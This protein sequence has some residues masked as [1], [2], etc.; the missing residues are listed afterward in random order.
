MAKKFITGTL[1]KI[2]V[3]GNNT[4]FL[5]KTK[6][7][8]VFTNNGVDVDTDV[9][10][11]HN[12]LDGL[13]HHWLDGEKD[14]SVYTTTCTNTGI[15]EMM[16]SGS[17]AAG[18][19][20]IA[21]GDQ[22]VALGLNSNAN[23]KNSFA[24]GTVTKT[25]GNFSMT[26]GHYVT[27]SSAAID[28]FAFGKYVN[29]NSPES[30]GIGY[31]IISSERGPSGGLVN[32][33]VSVG[34]N[35][36]AAS[37]NGIAV[38]YNVA[39]IGKNNAV[40][41][42]RDINLPSNDGL[43]LGVMIN[44]NNN[45]H[46][47]LA[48]GKRI[49]QS[50]AVNGAFAMGS[51]I[52]QGSNAV[53]IGRQIASY[54]SA[55]A[56]SNSIVLIGDSITSNNGVSDSILVGMN[57]HISNNSKKNVIY[58]HN[59]HASS[60]KTVSIGIGMSTACNNSVIIATSSVSGQ[61]T[62]TSSDSVIIGY[63][64]L[65]KD[66]Y[67]DS[68][69]N[70]H[71][72]SLGYSAR[73]NGSY[74]T[75][76]GPFSH[77]K[78][79]R[80]VLIGPYC[81]ISA[82]DAVA[83]GYRSNSSNNQSVAIGNNAKAS[84]NG[85][86]SIGSNCSSQSTYSIALGSNALSNFPGSVS[87]GYDTKATKYYS[88]ALGLNTISNGY[89]SISAGNNTSVQGNYS[90]G[91]GEDVI[92]NGIHSI[93]IGNAEK[94]GDNKYKLE[95]YGNYSYGHGSKIISTSKF[96]TLI[97]SNITVGNNV[98]TT[99]SNLKSVNYV[100]IK[101]KDIT[102][103]PI[104]MNN[105]NT[106]FN[107]FSFISGSNVSTN[108]PDSIIIGRDVNAISGRYF[109]SFGG[110]NEE[111]SGKSIILARNTSTLSTS[112]ML[113]SHNSTVASKGS[114]IISNMSKVGSYNASNP[115]DSV[116]VAPNLSLVISQKSTLDNYIERSVLIAN[117]IPASSTP[118]LYNTLMV[119][120]TLRKPND[121]T[122]SSKI[123]NSMVVAVQSSIAEINSSSIVTSGNSS[124]LKTINSVVVGSK[125]CMAVDLSDA[126]N[127][128]YKD[129]IVI[130]D[131][132]DFMNYPDE[133]GSL[134]QSS[135]NVIVGSNIS[136][137]GNVPKVAGLVLAG[138]EIITHGSNPTEHEVGAAY[139]M[140]LGEKVFTDSIGGS[141]AIGS[142]SNKNTSNRIG[143]GRVSNSIILANDHNGVNKLYNGSDTKYFGKYSDESLTILD[144]ES[145]F[146]ST[147]GSIMVLQNSCF[148]GKP[149]VTG[150][151]ASAFIEAN[152]L[153]GFEQHLK[154]SMIMSS[155]SH[156]K[157]GLNNS[158]VSISDSTIQGWTRANTPAI[159]NNNYN[160]EVRQPESINSS[161]FI[162]TNNSSIAVANRVI[163]VTNSTYTHIASDLLV[164]G[165]NNG[166]YDI[167]NS[168]VIGSRNRLTN[169]DGAAS[170]GQ[171]NTVDS[172]STY[173]TKNV[174]L[175]GHNLKVAQQNECTIVG[176][177]NEDT[178]AYTS[179][180]TV[181]DG[182]DISSLKN[183]FSAGGTGGVRG[184]AYHST[185]AD[186]AEYMEWSDGNLNDDDRCGLFVTFD[187]S[188]S[189]KLT[190]KIANESSYLMGIVSG[191]PSIIGN[192]DMEWSK[193]YLTDKF[194][195]PIYKKAQDNNG[196]EIEILEINP[197]YDSSK[198]YELRKNRK[199]WDTIGMRGFV[200]ARDDGTCNVGSYV[201]SNNS[202]YATHSD[203][204]TKFMCVLKKDNGTVLIDIN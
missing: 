130:G 197:D 36:S 1:T 81:N 69:D 103:Y 124:V 174:Y 77:V 48:I 179:R 45:S 134:E 139:S 25:E 171:D 52:I 198:D 169:C 51:A 89:Y 5:P 111:G 73:S 136:I 183:V 161:I 23:A 10:N 135:A 142:K 29:V 115:D 119:G 118:K 28:S 185:G 20:S 126:N 61:S 178:T 21:A 196:N 151:N 65:D 37:N 133:S 204:V 24:L 158:F 3:E 176:K 156:I 116:P 43:A 172:S 92:V 102:T 112:S 86:I 27:T 202:G 186:Y 57:M 55:D 15:Y 79:E 71:V 128:G 147:K 131:G 181:A 44:V 101:G 46:D 129:C 180:F 30:M 170:I 113:I 14:G 39:A 41:L 53:Q 26:Q 121:D 67:T 99:S 96:N 49:V 150:T 148:D 164:I 100:T 114:V 108:V 60:N 193:K 17:V 182:D 38:G 157:T 2:D 74:S 16:G 201:T 203:K 155:N 110:L 149:T 88:T 4:I 18:L 64:A 146:Q 58:G 83:I 143:F 8:L 163:S 104:D 194:G 122:D 42:G 153:N 76:I 70:H 159:V 173:P 93:A 11:I 117:N 168:L 137:L 127:K 107:S 160:V 9:S 184:T 125:L 190:I 78:G 40:A 165:D 167:C 199:E 152:G 95:L 120:D 188:V 177:F 72:L 200:I 7:S 47:N 144:S 87:I 85:S 63:G 138:N 32:G 66:N 166:L 31:N 84:G 90:M 106:E 59:M 19:A 91:Y 97:G 75:S 68:V 132:I 189:D 94:S 50:V 62:I 33:S 175:F 80:S 82:S 13:S 6:A 191:N 123:S 54:S 98:Y 22:S 56:V 140:L 12:E 141:I 34:R 195:R 162:G 187:S 192:A 154:N 35:I 109:F 145:Y 105:N